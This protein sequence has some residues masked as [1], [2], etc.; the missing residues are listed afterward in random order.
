MGSFPALI[1]IKFL[2]SF[3]S[4]PFTN[5]GFDGILDIGFFGGLITSLTIEFIPFF[6]STF[7]SFGKNATSVEPR[8]SFLDS[9]LSGYKIN[10]VPLPPQP[11]FGLVASTIQEVILPSLSLFNTI[12]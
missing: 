11:G 12:F 10:L 5:V 9:S 1:I 4:F 3:G 7:I 2:R 6:I 8:V